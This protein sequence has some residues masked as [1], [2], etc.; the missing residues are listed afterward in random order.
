MNSKILLILLCVTL[1]AMPKVNFGQAPNLG[2][3]SD[4]VL[5][6]TVGAVGN[7]G[8]SQLTGMWA[9]TTGPLQAL[10]M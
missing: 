5:F 7:T 2:T 3:A 4:F 10:E 6:S 1:F 8:I 9:R